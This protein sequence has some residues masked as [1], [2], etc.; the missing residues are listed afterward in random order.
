MQIF[1]NCHVTLTPR[2]LAWMRRVAKLRNTFAK[3]L[4]KKILDSGVE[5]CPPASP[6]IWRERIARILCVVPGEGDCR[7]CPYCHHRLSRG[8]AF[9]SDTCALFP[10]QALFVL[11]LCS[12]CILVMV[13]VPATYTE[14]RDTRRREPASSRRHGMAPSSRA[15]FV[16]M[17]IFP[18]CNQK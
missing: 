4:F 16:Q 6:S 18:Q 2:A 8:S 12:L 15:A 11:E 10:R 1:H 17:V 9:Y 13:K 3:A 5:A 7:A 14:R